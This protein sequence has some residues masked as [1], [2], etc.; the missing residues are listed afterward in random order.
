MDISLSPFAPENLVLRDGFGSLVPRQPAHL[1]IQAEPGAYLLTGFI[2]SSTA[3]SIYLCKL[4]YVPGQSRVYQA[5]Q[6]RA[7]GVHCR[8][9]GPVNLKVVSNGCCLDRSP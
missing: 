8:E 2:P 5:T 7:D 9:S 1:H 4:S 3:V 6:L